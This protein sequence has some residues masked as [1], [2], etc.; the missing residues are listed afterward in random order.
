MH[1]NKVTYT[2]LEQLHGNIC[3][4]GARKNNDNTTLIFI[5]LNKTT[6]KTWMPQEKI[7]E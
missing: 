2:Q 6:Q 7:K 1:K 3:T 4:T 5:G